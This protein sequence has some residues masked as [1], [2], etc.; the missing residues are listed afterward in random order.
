M[1]L[2]LLCKCHSLPLTLTEKSKRRGKQNPRQWLPN[3]C[4]VYLTPFSKGTVERAPAI[5]GT[6]IIHWHSLRPAWAPH[7][8][9]KGEVNMSSKGIALM[10]IHLGK[11]RQSSFEYN[12][13]HC[14][15][16]ITAFF[17][18]WRCVVILHGASLMAPVFPTVFSHFVSLSHIWSFSQYF[19]LFH[20]YYICYG[21]IWYYYYYL[22]KA[23][24]M[25]SIL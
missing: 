23:Q 11:G 17:T 4:S 8:T 16:Q 5:G 22:P 10:Q 12:W 25:V 1:W 19:T 14:A 18:N 9:V 7:G 6:T 24:M 20:Y 2:F 13:F 15:S 21:D 3:W